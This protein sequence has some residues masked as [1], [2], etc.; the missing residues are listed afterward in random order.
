MISICRR[1]LLPDGSTTCRPSSMEPLF[2]ISSV[3]VGCILLVVQLWVGHRASIV[4][5][6]VGKVISSA[7]VG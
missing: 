2:I 3:A 4:Q 5:I 7:A 6:C 1:R